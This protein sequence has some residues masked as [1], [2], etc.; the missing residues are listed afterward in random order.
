MKEKHIILWHISSKK[1]LWSQQPAVTRQRPVNNNRGR[2][3]SE[4]SVPM[5]EHATMES[6]A[7]AKQQLNRTEERCFRADVL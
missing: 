5:A 2:V 4:Q 3:F 6:H 1:E 7:I